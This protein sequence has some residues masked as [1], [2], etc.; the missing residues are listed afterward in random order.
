MQE[1]QTDDTEDTME[2]ENATEE[3]TEN[4]MNQLQFYP[5]P[6]QCWVVPR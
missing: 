3:R 2:G 5:P 6:T 1:N 4:P